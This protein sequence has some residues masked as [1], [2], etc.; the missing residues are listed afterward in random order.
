MKRCITFATILLL[1]GSSIMV[2]AAPGSAQEKQTLAILDFDGLGISQQEAQL[3]TNRLRTILVQMEVYN[4]IE[5]GQME[6]ILQEQNFQLTGCTSQECAVEVGQVLGAQW[7]M[8]GSIGKI[9]QTFTVDL[10]IINVETSAIDRTASYDIRGEIDQM[11]TEGMVEVARRITGKSAPPTLP[12]PK[13]TVP[14]PGLLSLTSMPAGARVFIN[15]MERGAT[16]ITNAEMPAGQEIEVRFMMEGYETASK[17]VSIAEGDNPPVAVTL[18]PLTSVVSVES[19]PR[20]ARV[21]IDDDMVGRSPVAGL[22]YRVG[23]HT[24]EVKK[25]GF[26]PRLEQFRVEADSPSLLTVQ[27]QPKSRGA[28]FFL[29]MVIPGAGHFYRGKPFGG[30]LFMAGTAAVGYLTYDANTQF[31][32]ARTEYDTILEEYNKETDYQRALLLRE[33]VQGAFDE[34]KT[35]QASQTRYLQILGGVYGLN[36]LTVVF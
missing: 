33:D 25:P 17:N 27:L 11:L 29:S 4:V 10:R 13:A 16:P 18:K 36:L 34:M 31:Q 7:M 23:R 5:R 12:P 9:G 21:F 24:L 8:T 3:L 6:Q 2:P 26:R 15:G 1:L 35:R 22:P 20:R 14:E 30:F 19:R 32:D 28:A